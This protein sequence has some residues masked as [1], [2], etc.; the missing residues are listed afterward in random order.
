M[1]TLNPD[2]FRSAP[3]EAEA[4]P[5]PS[6]LHTPPVTKMYLHKVFNYKTCLGF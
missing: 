6:E 4:I 3:I 5:L 2:D 1:N